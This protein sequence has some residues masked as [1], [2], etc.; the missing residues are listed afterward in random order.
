MKI[1][2]VTGWIT[3]QQA[4]ITD[5]HNHVWIEPVPESALGSP[6]LVEQENI[7]K[8]LI[9]YHRVGGGTIVDCQ[10]GGCGR[11]GRV[12]YQLSR[13]TQVNIVSSTGFHLK[14]YYQ[15]E[16][17]LFDASVEKA[18]NFFLDEL[19]IGLAETLETGHPVQAG[20]IK[21]ACQESLDESP[22][23]LL[24]AAVMASLETDSAIE[25][26]TEKGLQGE[27]IVNALFDLG[28]SPDNIILCH[29]DKRMDFGFH[30]QLLTAGITLE[31]DTFFRSKY[32][33]DENVWP[34]LEQVVS[35]GFED[36]IVVATDL[37]DSTQWSR[38]GYGPGL[39]GL[40]N[41]LIPRMAE[42][43]FQPNTI[44]KLVGWNIASRLARSAE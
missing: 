33:P 19:R 29:V 42:I 5:A 15:P 1:K 2:T 26:H 40:I 36:Q 28:L 14:K 16:Y 24:E 41:L 10:P 23:N 27:Q 39:V 7:T 25:V 8:E 38:L 43:G 21:T 32:H 34:L 6:V 35:A 12:L 22:M 18:T 9:D 31:Y 20:F 44:K 13:E 30:H 4:G 3:P 11:N 17:W 37:A